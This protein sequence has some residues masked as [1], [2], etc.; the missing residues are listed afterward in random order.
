M[1]P[2]NILFITADQWRGQCLSALN[3]PVVKTPNLD[4]L[5]RE[6]TLFARHFSNTSPCSPSR[7]TLHTG[8]YQH[9]HRVAMNGTP[10]DR[11]HTNWAI[12][13][14]KLGY[15]PALIGY[16]DQ[17]VDPR[18]VAPGDPRLTTYESIL[19]G[20]TDFAATSMDFPNDWAKFLRARGY[21]MP[22]EERHIIWS[23]ESGADYEDGASHPKPWI[24]KAEHND[25]T[26]HVDQAIDYVSQNRSEPWILHLSLLRPHPP[27]IASEPWNR[28]YD[29]ETLPPPTRR[30]T[31]DDE[32][33][34]HPW[35]SHQLKHP[36]Y[37]A[38]DD[39][40][41]LNRMRAVYFAMISE[42]DENLGR[43]FEHLKHERLWD[44]TLIVFTSDHGEQLG[45]HWLLGKASYFDA[46]YAV[47]LIVRDPRAAADR[48]RGQTVHAFTEHVDIMPT[49]LDAIGTEVP[50][51]CDGSSLMPLVEALAPAWRAEAHFEFDFRDASFDGAEQA[52][53]LTLHQCNFSILRGERFKYAHFANLPPLLFDLERDPHE[54]TNLATA[55]DYAKVTLACAQKLMSWRLAHEDQT[56]THLMATGKGMIARPTPRF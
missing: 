35:L 18:D 24:V 29:P 9:N 49:L 54:F 15:D 11:R 38:P 51:Q 48:T 28:L 34:Q 33:A 21:E 27:W 30:E 47:P 52:L 6:G 50:P 20:L 26:W 44:D 7:A 3:H 19:P 31:R 22:P 55:A 13:A 42:V 2:R 41:K 1:K 39:I 17:T 23:R 14:R 5:A 12:E 16:T 53:G 32:A 4:A 46:T 8:L 10:L 45:D 37:Q 25:T 56:L 43:L 36:L 40:R